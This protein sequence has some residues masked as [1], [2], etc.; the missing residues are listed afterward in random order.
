MLH[1]SVNIYAENY[2]CYVMRQTFSHP[3]KMF[4][5][6]SIISAKL[7]M[8]RLPNFWFLQKLKRSNLKLQR[9]YNL[10]ST[11]KVLQALMLLLITFKIMSD[12]FWSVFSWKVMKSLSFSDFHLISKVFKRWFCLLTCS[13]PYILFA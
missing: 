10:C 6:S 7:T 5:F 13:R 11:R 2:H 12:N 8:M 9:A 4:R 1:E 3:L